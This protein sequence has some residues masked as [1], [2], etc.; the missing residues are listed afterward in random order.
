MHDYPFIRDATQIKEQSWQPS[1]SLR[2]WWRLPSPRGSCRR[3]WGSLCSLRSATR[4]PGRPGGETEL[5]QHHNHDYNIIMSILCIIIII[6]IIMTRRIRPPRSLKVNGWWLPTWDWETRTATPP[7][8]SPGLPTPS[9]RSP[10]SLM[11]W[12][13]RVSS[14]SSG[15]ICLSAHEC[16]TKK[17]VSQLPLC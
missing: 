11:R 14:S 8:T 10:P 3:W 4:A 5:Q 15:S 1:L 13:W 17:V 2:T 9:R 6:I 12:A 16:Q 7:G